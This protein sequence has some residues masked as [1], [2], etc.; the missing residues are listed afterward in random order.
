VS[1]S[2]LAA[3]ARR[4]VVAVALVL[5][6]A[7]GT[8][9]AFKHTA[10]TYQESATLVLTAPR[11]QPYTAFGSSL[12]TTGELAA[13]W[14]M[15]QQ[16]EPQVA[17][18]AGGDDFSVALVNFSNQEYPYDV[19]PYLTVS[20]SAGSPAAAHRAF[21]A[22]TRAVDGYLAARQ[23]AEQIAPRDLIGTRLVGDTGAVLQQGS[24]LRSFA[25]LAVLT[26]V[27]AYLVSRFLDRHP[28][29]LRVLLTGSQ[30]RSTHH[31]VS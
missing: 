25:G 2:E 17:R 22:V 27:A 26:T 8:A 1:L 23:R 28:I 18:A 16:G 4:H 7:A 14:V 19:V 21:L 10:P 24:R 13:D 31:P 3:L 6:A 30:W 20:A 15:G 5:L 11:P 9:Y 29:R 12:V